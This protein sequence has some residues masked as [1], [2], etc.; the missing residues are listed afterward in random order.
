MKVL[1][2]HDVNMTPAVDDHVTYPESDRP[3]A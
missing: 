2:D 1:R 3:A